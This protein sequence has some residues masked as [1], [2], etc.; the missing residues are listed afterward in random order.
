MIAPGAGVRVYPVRHP[1]Q[2]DPG[3]VRPSVSRNTIHALT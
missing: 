1:H 3:F 2:A